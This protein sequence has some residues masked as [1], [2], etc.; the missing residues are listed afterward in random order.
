MNYALS[1]TG[2]LGV[3]LNPTSELEP[4]NVA[5]LRR[6]DGVARDRPGTATSARETAGA[7]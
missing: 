2:A 7:R 3:V 1:A 5:A 4:T 6:G